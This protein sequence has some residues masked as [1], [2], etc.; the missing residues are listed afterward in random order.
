M[1]EMKPFASEPGMLTLR[2]VISVL[3]DAPIS[4]GQKYRHLVI[5]DM[6]GRAI[7]AALGLRRHEEMAPAILLRRESEISR[8][9]PLSVSAGSKT[10]A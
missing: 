2:G 1:T 3:R 4:Y 8:S 10:L 6:A 7:Q 5:E 9:R